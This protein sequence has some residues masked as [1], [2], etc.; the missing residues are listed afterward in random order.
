MH[1]NLVSA[2]TAIVNDAFFQQC[3]RAVDDIGPELGSHRAPFPAE[4]DI[5][6]VDA[7]HALVL[8]HREHSLHEE[9]V[10]P[11]EVR[12]AALQAGGGFLHDGDRTRTA[13][14]NEY[15]SLQGSAV[16]EILVDKMMEAVAE[17]IARRQDVADGEHPALFG[18]Y[19]FIFNVQPGNDMIHNLP[20]AG[21]EMHIAHADTA[22]IASLFQGVVQPAPQDGQDVHIRQVRVRV[23]KRE[24]CRRCRQNSLICFKTNDFRRSQQGTGFVR[25]KKIIPVGKTRSMH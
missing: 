18:A 19:L 3:I 22:L 2:G 15:Q 6:H 8:V 4:I 9:A 16:L 24:G 1:R 20:L 14:G 7:A 21:Q 5:R 11:L 10:H 13:D 25:C 17:G 12:V 23:Q